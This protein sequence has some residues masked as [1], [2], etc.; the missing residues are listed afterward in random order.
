VQFVAQ[1]RCFLEFEIGGGIAHALV[2]FLQIGLQVVA[3]EVRVVLVA[4]L[5]R[6]RIL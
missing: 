6:E 5:D 1:A 2:K 4:G 3:D